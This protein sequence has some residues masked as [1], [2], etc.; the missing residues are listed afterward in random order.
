[1]FFGEHRTDDDST[2]LDAVDSEG[3]IQLG[4]DGVRPV[5][6][7]KRPEFPLWDVIKVIFKREAN[8][9]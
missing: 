6:V 3:S 2:C 8:Y 9:N 1:V 5:Q 4:G 7:S